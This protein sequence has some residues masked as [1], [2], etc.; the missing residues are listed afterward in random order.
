MKKGFVSIFFVLLV[1]VVALILTA[2]II[3][4]HAMRIYYPRQYSEIISETAE[5]FDLD[6]DLLY[7]VIHAESKFNSGAVSSAGAS[8]LMQIT[9]ETF[10][11]IN[12]KFPPHSN[13]PDSFNPSDNIHAGAAL[14]RLL[15]DTYGDTDTALAAY[16]AGM[17]NASKWLADENYSSD[18]ITLK[19]IPFPETA[20][21]VKRVNKNYSKYKKLY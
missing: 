13:T 16:N 14:L 1:L 21:Y 6:E 10:D 7:A 15:I 11:W 2:P 20:N 9:D 17:G 8:G 5:K 19:H 4:K 3:Y 12:G 18:G